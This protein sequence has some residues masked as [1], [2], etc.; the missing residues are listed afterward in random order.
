MLAI[1]EKIENGGETEE[2]QIINVEDEAQS[3]PRSWEACNT[4]EGFVPMSEISDAVQ[5]MV[6]KSFIFGKAR[7]SV[8]QRSRGVVE[9]GLLYDF[10]GNADCPEIDSETWAIDYSN[11]R[12]W[13]PLH[14]DI[15]IP[16]RN[17]TPI[18]AAAA[19]TVVEKFKNKK[20]RKGIEV[21]IRRRPEQIGLPHWTYSQYT[22]LLSMSSLTID[23]SVRMGQEVG[24]TSNNERWGDRLEG[25][26][27]TVLFCIT[28]NLPGLMMVVL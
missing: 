26:H 28:K 1:I 14:K 25:T 2:E 8:P 5:A 21:M 16:Q 12:P 11:K 15:D 22:N 9:T 3:P 13:S 18:L 27:F 6:G 24:K 4:I 20:N 19:G 7:A 17:E 10:I 23:Q